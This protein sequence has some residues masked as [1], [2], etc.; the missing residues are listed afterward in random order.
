MSQVGYF[1]VTAAQKRTGALL[2]LP[3]GCFYM[4]SSDCVRLILKNLKSL[5]VTLI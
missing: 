1:I 3:S 4:W 2:Y 5:T